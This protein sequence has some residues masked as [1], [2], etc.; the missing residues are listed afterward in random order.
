MWLS[1][2]VMMSPYLETKGNLLQLAAHA[3]KLFD[4]SP[5]TNKVLGLD[6]AGTHLAV[7]GARLDLLDE[8]LFLLL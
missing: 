4:I 5:C 1:A 2:R 7:L 3:V 6:L 8:R